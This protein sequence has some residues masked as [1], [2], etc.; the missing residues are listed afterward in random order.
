MRHGTR[1]RYGLLVAILAV[2]AVP[3]A[4][5]ADGPR[6]RVLLL[7][8]STT[9]GSVCRQVEPKGPHLEDVIRSLLAAEPDLPPA[10]VV[11]QG[12][13]GEL[14]HGLLSSGRYDR[15]I[16]PLGL[17]DYIFIRYGLN[18]VARREAFEANFPGD[19]AELIGRL[20]RNFPG[21]AIVPMTIIPYMTPERDEAVNWLIRR[22]AEA[23]HLPLLDVYSRYAAELKRGP[24]MLN[25]R[26]Y[27]LEEIP[28]RH[29]AWVAPFVRDG[30]VV[31]MD[32]RL[33]AHFRDLPGWFADRHPN[34]AGYHVLGDETAK[35]LARSIRAKKAAAATA[36]PTSG[37][38]AGLAAT[39]L[40]FLDTGFEN[41]SPLW[42]EAAPDGAILVHLLYDH[43][44]S[45]PNRAA[46]HIHFRIVAKPST[47]LT[48]EFRN[49]DNV[50]NGRPASI[51][52]E[53]KVVVVSPDGKAWKPVPLERLPGDRVRLAVT[54]P[55]PS[56]Y[57]ARA[58][59]YRLSDLEGWLASIAKNPLVEVTPVG[60]TAEGRGLE[61]VRVGR[62]DAP[63]RVF[64][65]ARAHPWE[66]GGNWVIQ[67][68]VERLLRGDDEATRYL[69]RYCVYALP[70]ANKDGVAR[71]RTRFNL[72]GKDLNRDW[73]RPADPDLAPENHA[74]E[75]WLEA[76]IRRGQK[77]HL[78]LELHND[79]GGLL[80]I[81]RP[82]VPGLERH[83][84]RM[85]TLES[86]LRKH[87]WFTEGSTSESFHNAGTLGEGWLLRYGIDAAVHELNVNRIAG[88]DDYPSAA[89]WMLYGGQLP[90]VISE[91]F[92]VVKP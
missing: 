26:R 47:A 8:D 92:D 50:W 46:G 62:P 19:Y 52:D 39:G 91:Y 67:G 90:R 12:R 31:V 89:H 29:R 64:L 11:N 68:L 49:L 27:P 38:P 7:G 57:V 81:S 80:H 2:P 88:L 13:D 24:D 75:A 40:E 73:D 28:E 78:A 22:V 20:R 69:E 25:Y 70:M 36:P 85:K 1:W 42:Y 14:I 82:P 35:F 59:P 15:E 43:E 72:R 18:D 54:M 86:L 53:L 41:A 37:G 83:V 71:G 10:E 34:P 4:A 16:V 79:G 63:H 58:E 55:G 21:A 23:E 9:I 30:K 77:P 51:A 56:L 44:R 76:M 65:R 84:A 33:D 6:L 17:F 5:A 60:R 66:P 32:N 74:L 45:S 3:A 61:V 48:L 87:T